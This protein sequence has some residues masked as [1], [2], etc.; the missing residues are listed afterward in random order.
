MPSDG[1]TLT[2]AEI[3]SAVNIGSFGGN[4]T[5]D[6]NW[7][8]GLYHNWAIGYGYSNGMPLYGGVKCGGSKYHIYWLKD[9]NKY[10]ILSSAQE[11]K[12]CGEMPAE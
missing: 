2:A 8:Y 12:D 3:Q 7:H 5:V 10:V 9:R 11:P 1:D 4:V 6:K